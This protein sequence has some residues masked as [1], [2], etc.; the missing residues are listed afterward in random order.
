MLKTTRKK[1]VLDSQIITY[2]CNVTKENESPQ[3]ICLGQLVRLEG[4][5]MR[6]TAPA[7]EH[8]QDEQ[9]PELKG[10]LLTSAACPPTVSHPPPVKT[11]KYAT[12]LLFNH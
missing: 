1:D 11:H 3:L 8:F 5:C 7:L 4:N 10:G 2:L 6:D 12:Q 9:Y